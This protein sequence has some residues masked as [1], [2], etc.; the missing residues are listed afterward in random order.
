M[1]TRLKNSSF[2]LQEKDVKSFSELKACKAFDRGS[3]RGLAF[4]I[5]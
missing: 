1:E 5:G 4:V 3:R 2:E